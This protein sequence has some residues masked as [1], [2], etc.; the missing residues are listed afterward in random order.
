M[1]TDISAAQW[2]NVVWEGLY[3]LHFTLAFLLFLLKA[4]EL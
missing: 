2:A 4:M 3:F 1:E